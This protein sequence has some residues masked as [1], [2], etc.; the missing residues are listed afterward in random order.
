MFLKL[1]Q[2]QACVRSDCID[3][4]KAVANLMRF[5]LCVAFVHFYISDFK[6][7]RREKN[8]SDSFLFI[9]VINFFSI[10]LNRV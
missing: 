5:I 9:V 6:H 8:L 4:S 2:S 1:D 7:K 10:L 3:L